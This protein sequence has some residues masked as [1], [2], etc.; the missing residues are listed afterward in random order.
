MLAP[1]STVSTYI[2][3]PVPLSNAK[4]GTIPVAS[5]KVIVVD[6]E[7]TSP[8]TVG[9]KKDPPPAELSITAVVCEPVGILA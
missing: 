2:A 1:R 7:G 8:I 3:V 5:S 6:P 4:F 9:V